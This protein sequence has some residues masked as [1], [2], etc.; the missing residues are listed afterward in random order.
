MPS[1][2][3]DPKPADKPAE[4]D[5][6]ATKKEED[7]NLDHDGRERQPNQQTGKKT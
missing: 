7:K 3:T 6:K 1:S 5:A 2:E 4:K